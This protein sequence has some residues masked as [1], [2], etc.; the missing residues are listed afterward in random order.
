MQSG[1]E[2][3]QP[4]GAPRW[5]AMFHQ[6]SSDSWRVG[7]ESPH[8]FPVLYAVGEMAQTLRARGEHPTVA[9]WG[10]R[11]GAWER[12]EHLAAGPAAEQAPSAVPEEPGAVGGKPDKLAERMTDRRQQVL[13]AGLGKAGLYDLSPDDLAA[14]ETLVDRLDETTVRSV[15]HWLAVASGDR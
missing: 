14:V 1:L 6:P 2:S 15:A 7:A 11:D 8:R 3:P 9:L 13:M 5:V 10:P 12:H 4:P